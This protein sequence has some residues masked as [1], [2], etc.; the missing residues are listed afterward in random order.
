MHQI[1]EIGT[2]TFLTF[3]NVFQIVGWT[4]TLI[5]VLLYLK[6]GRFKMEGLDD[7]EVCLLT[8]RITQ[9]MQIGEIIFPLLKLSPG[10]PFMS[11]IQIASRIIIVFAFLDKTTSPFIAGLILIPWSLADSVRAAFYIFK[12]NKILLHLRYNLFIVLYPLGVMGEILAIED[13]IHYWRNYYFWLRTYQ[14]ATVCGLAFLYMYLLKA[15]AKV[16]KREN[17]SHPN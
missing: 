16:Y 3:F 17:K 5:Q 11:F 13:K 7:F 15:R 2:R 10:S 8:A 6:E 14:I 4:L 12:N 9:I 1:K